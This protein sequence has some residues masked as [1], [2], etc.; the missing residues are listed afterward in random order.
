[1]VKKELKE[2]DGKIQGFIKKVLE[3][4]KDPKVLIIIGLSV[5]L[6]IVASS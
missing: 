2:V 5:A 6:A 3:S 4:F 1:M